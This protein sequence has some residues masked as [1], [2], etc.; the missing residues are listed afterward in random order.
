[1]W[2]MRP[3]STWG[4]DTPATYGLLI[5][6]IALFIVA[7]FGGG[8]FVA[9]LAWPVSVEWFRSLAAW[10]PLTFPLVHAPQ[11]PWNLLF[12]GLVLFFFGGSLERAWGSARFLLFF[13]VSGIIAGGVVLLVAPHGE[14]AF[15]GMIGSYVA[16]SV[17]FA[18]INPHATV[19]FFVFPIQALW[20]GPIAIVYE[21]F[22]RN[23]YYGGPVPA[24]VSIAVVSLFGWAYATHR[25][26]IASWRGLSFKER[27]ARWQQRRRWRKWQREASRIQKPSDLFKR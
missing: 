5:A 9:L 16:C 2:R 27:L 25:L 22:F 26:D 19:I 1:M 20:L 21:L 11:N 14:A 7:L 17:A 8:A 13:A 4:G 18:S 23:A 6:M 12:D 15:I 3:Q 24:A 10:Q